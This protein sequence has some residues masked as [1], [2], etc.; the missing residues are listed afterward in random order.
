MADDPNLIRV[1]GTDR[2]FRRSRI[3]VVLLI[4]IA[5]ALVAVSS[6]NVALPTISHTLGATDSDLQWVLSGYALTFGISLVPAGRAGDVLG[7][8]TFFVLGLLVFSLASLAC[9]LAPN[10]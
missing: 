7:R 10:P 5:M 8:G 2:V 3:L 6:I 1:E 9:G 4:P